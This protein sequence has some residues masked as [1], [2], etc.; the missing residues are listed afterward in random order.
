M[1]RLLCIFAVLFSGTAVSHADWT[2][3]FSIRGYVRETPLVWE[4]KR[5]FGQPSIWYVNSITHTRQ[6]LR[7][8]PSYSV[9]GA[10]ELKTRLFA[11]DVARRLRQSTELTSQN[12][13][14]LD[15]EHEFV[16]EDNALLVVTL[17]R[18]WLDITRGPIQM[19][20]GR[21][22]IAWGT[23]L[24][25]NPIDIFNPRNP[26]DFENEELPGSDAVRA[27]YYLG[28]NS[29]LE[30]AFAPQ[31]D[32]DDAIGAVKLQINKWTYDWIVLAGR[33]ASETVIGGA[34]SGDISGG[35]FRGEL[36]YAKPRESDPEPEG[37]VV[38]TVAGDYTFR[39]TQYLHAAVLY[40]ERGATENAGGLR[41]LKAYQRGELT[42][43]RM[44]IFARAA[45]DLT[46]L[47]RA[48]LSAILNPYDLSYYW[49]PGLTWSVITNLDLNL[50]ALIF[51]G[52]P[53]EEFGL[54]GDIYMARLKYSF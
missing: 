19:T 54:V 39:N 31:D 16:K 4:Q 2:E 29:K 21:Q 52:D 34:F 28:P 13:T 8:Y 48:D 44:S 42:P 49:S 18:V 40:N 6:N 43:A 51:D 41:L 37:Y 35:G 23:S 38:A 50:L 30:A 7:W 3:N 26:L 47:V 45:R 24:V 46:P 15:L 10:V 17:D 22:R 11:G 32:I 53:N 14:W 9:I 25:W 33:R 20:V 27:Q 1:I 12:T 36:L 5:L